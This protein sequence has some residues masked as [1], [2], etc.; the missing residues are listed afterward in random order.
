MLEYLKL[1]CT[2]NSHGDYC[3][4]LLDEFN[5][6]QL[7]LPYD[8]MNV[9]YRCVNGIVFVMRALCVGFNLLSM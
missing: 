9:S 3:L 1:F 8:D 4:E 5:N 6:G 7:Q 2:H